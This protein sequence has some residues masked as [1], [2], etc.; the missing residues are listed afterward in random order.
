MTS[1]NLN[2]DDYI[3]HHSPPMLEGTHTKPPLSIKKTIKEPPVMN[4][5]NKDGWKLNYWFSDN[6]LRKHKQYNIGRFLWFETPSYVS[7]M[8]MVS[9][10]QPPVIRFVWNLQEACNVIILFN[11]KENI[12][13]PKKKEREILSMLSRNPT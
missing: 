8:L 7:V 13:Y 2:L 1:H 4:K 5:K 12:K 9:S 10:S 6:V 3:I 11:I